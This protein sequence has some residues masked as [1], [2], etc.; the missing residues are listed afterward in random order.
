MLE[1]KHATS[2]TY[3]P[4]TQGHFERYNRT[5][6]AQVRTYIENDLDKWDELVSVLTVAYNTRP[7]QSTGVASFEFVM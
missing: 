5:M 7:K 1:I 3:H 2:T 4:Q 6:V